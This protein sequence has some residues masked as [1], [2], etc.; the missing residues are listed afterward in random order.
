MRDSM[1][2]SISL[3]EM[4]RM[5]HRISQRLCLEKR[6]SGQ[7][8]MKRGK[9]MGS[10]TVLIQAERVASGTMS[11]APVVPRTRPAAVR[12][13]SQSVMLICVIVCL[14]MAAL[15]LSACGGFR[16]DGSWKITE[17]PAQAYEGPG[18]MWP[19][20]QVIV[21]DNGE[22]NLMPQLLAPNATYVLEE[23][24][25]SGSYTLTVSSGWNSYTFSL[26]VISNNEIEIGSVP[27]YDGRVV[28]KRS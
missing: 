3:K 1:A 22:T 5:K 13:P 8:E 4:E 12:K 25:G 14:C 20:G 7:Q 6:Q 15:T 21:F 28:L 16:L 27:N 18:W 9:G 10:P 19:K 26:R 11:V 17:G 24:G 2:D 23:R